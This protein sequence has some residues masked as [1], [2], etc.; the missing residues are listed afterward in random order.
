MPIIRSRAPVRIS[1]GGGGTDLSPYTEEYGGVVL[2]AAINRYAYTTFIPRDDKKIILD[3]YDLNL[4]LEYEDISKIELNG[5]LD[6]VKSVILYFKEHHPHFFEKHPHGFEIHTNCEIPPRSGLGSSASMFASVIGI[7]NR[8]GREYRI[9]DYELA[10]LAFYLEREKL[11][12][13][14][15][16]QDQYATVFGGINFIEFKGD[17]FVRVNPFNLKPDY[18]LELESDLL[19]LNVG[20]REDSG[21]VITDQVENLKKDKK[22]I[23]AMHRTK[24]LTAQLKSVLIKGDFNRFG[25]LIDEAWQEKKKLSSKI[26]TGSIDEIYE[27]LQKVG[28]IGGKITGAGGGGHMLFYCRPGR[29]CHVRQKALD[30]GLKDVSFAFDYDGLTTW[31]I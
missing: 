25:E 5:E 13:A 19:L 8:L 14:G 15:G 2:N 7:F 26:S 28:G 23:E 30:L 3:S 21:D 12:N 18:L 22:S 11:N 10:E 24:E 4:R 1:F 6:L 27:K 17:N 16:R 9:D 31:I 29:R 20:K